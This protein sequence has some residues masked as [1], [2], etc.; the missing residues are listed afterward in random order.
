MAQ[1]QRRTL[2][3]RLTA[4]NETRTAFTQVERSLR[5][6]RT[7]GDRAF[8]G[9]TRAARSTKGQ[10]AALVATL[11]G[12]QKLV[13]DPAQFEEAIIRITLAG[14]AFVGKADEI[15]DAIDNLAT[16]TG[17]QRTELAAAFDVAARRAEDYAEAL[18]LVTTANKLAALSG[19]DVTE[20]VTGLD[21]V[22][23]AFGGSIADVEQ[24]AAQLFE[25]TRRLP[26]SQGEILTQLGNIAPQARLAG[27]GLDDLLAAI[28]TAEAQGIRA[29]TTF[30]AL[31]TILDQL[32][33]PAGAAADRFRDLGVQTGQNALAGQNLG[34]VFARIAAGAERVGNGLGDLGIRGRSV[35]AFLAI[36]S[37][38][39][40]R[41]R[42]TLDT[43][44]SASVPEFNAAFD[45]VNN[46]TKSAIDAFRELA[47]VAA[48][49]FGG[50]F[51]DDVNRALSEA[52][53]RTALI[54]L[55]AERV[56]LELKRWLTEIR[57]FFAL[58][59]AAFVS[60]ASGTEILA[61]AFADNFLVGIYKI[62]LAWAGAVLNFKDQFRPFIEGVREQF[63]DLYNFIA[64]RVPGLD[65]IGMTAKQTREELRRLAQ[66]QQQLLKLQ[67][68]APALIERFEARGDAVLLRKAAEFRERLKTVESDLE[69]VRQ[70]RLALLQTETDPFADDRADL[71]ALSAEVDR[72]AERQK[73]IGE[74]L[75]TLES[76]GER[77]RGAWLN[78][79][80]A[81]NSD[82]DR[83]NELADAIAQITAE[84][85]RLNAASGEIVPTPFAQPIG[86]ELPG[87]EPAVG[88]PTAGDL[89]AGTEQQVVP[90]GDDDTEQ[91]KQ[92]LT[93]LGQLLD[94]VS[95]K[96]E[97]ISATLE[98]SFSNAFADFIAGALSAEEAA[99]QFFQSMVR[100][101][102][103][104]AAQK[105]ATQI[106]SAFI[107][108]GSAAADGGIVEA[109]D[110]GVVAAFANGGV[111]R[112]AS[113]ASATT[114]RAFADGGPFVGAAQS[115]S[116]TRSRMFGLFAEA[117]LSEA[118]VPLGD[119]DAVPL[120]L[121]AGGRP[122]VALP[123]GRKIA[124][125]VRGDGITDAEAMTQL[126]GMLAGGGSNPV[127]GGIRGGIVRRPLLTQMPADGSNTAAIPLPNALGVPVTVHNDGNVT[128]DLPKGRE[129]PT[130]AGPRAARVRAPRVPVTPFANGGYLPGSN[131]GVS[132][133][134]GSAMASAVG[135]SGS[136]TST[137]S[138]AVY[139]VTIQAMDGPSVERVLSSPA[140][141]RSIEAAFRNAT[142]TRRDFRR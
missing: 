44:N 117:G 97:A 99:A 124:A 138:A 135:V 127:S 139:N 33:S 20:A 38:E 119:G 22:I 140:G 96:S 114:V 55:Q 78:V 112:S 61:R 41:F 69:A 28:A 13:I 107:G 88:A 60:L 16:S 111:S 21:S 49:A 126:E 39:G 63:T 12:I 1:T 58:L 7:A 29:S 103:E 46:T 6:I 137:P 34:E 93:E 131:I 86:P 42:D 9:I 136:M 35:S 100:G 125:N 115:S 141:K 25:T 56:A 101:L 123:G 70:A 32:T 102:A 105:L 134:S 11:G 52:N 71:V 68:E 113:S 142:V 23:E 108:G 37:D 53:S 73:P 129:L 133:A 4:R 90:G 95:L 98:Q 122:V 5:R 47:R 82:T 51:L 19:S 79:G 67:D 18:E 116:A 15:R 36:A 76:I 110:G 2:E 132:S 130:T 85:E 72:V 14:D 128:V 54:K 66:E 118:I 91:K 94:Q 57:P 84:I 121:D 48:D 31:R 77:V 109:A 26:E 17:T 45:T 89:T 50:V 81:L 65:P 59:N 92:N 27:L 43:L 30:T 83:A 104:L 40:E 75:A 80:D 24:I 8:Q 106:V 87:A 74:Q 62:R 120:R 3:T 10:L 64:E